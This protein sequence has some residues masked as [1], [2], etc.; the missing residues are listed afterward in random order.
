MIPLDFFFLFSLVLTAEKWLTIKWSV[1][2]FGP[3]SYDREIVTECVSLMVVAE[4]F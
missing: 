2:K 3:V 4:K 1:N